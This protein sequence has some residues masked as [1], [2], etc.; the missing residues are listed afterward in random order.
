[1]IKIITSILSLNVKNYN[2]LCVF[3]NKVKIQ[4]KIIYTYIWIVDEQ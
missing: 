2:V 4:Y 3:L 1:M